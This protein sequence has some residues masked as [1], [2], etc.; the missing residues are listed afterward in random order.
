MVLEHLPTP[1][2]RRFTLPPPA[3]SRVPPE[4][5]VLQVQQYAS[6]RQR[7]GLPASERGD[8]RA[9]EYATGMEGLTPRQLDGFVQ[10]VLDKY[11]AKRIDPGVGNCEICMRWD[12]TGQD[13]PSLLR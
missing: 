5:P 7:V 12:F 11:E 2:T 9:L 4:P 3:H 10:Q 13:F 6:A 8:S 1:F